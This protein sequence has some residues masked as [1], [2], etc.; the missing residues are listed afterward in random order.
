M[1]EVN[2]PI[3]YAGPGSPTTKIDELFEYISDTVIDDSELPSGFFSVRLA[4]VQE[5]LATNS[6]TV[7][8]DFARALLSARSLAEDM[9]EKDHD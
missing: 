2:E 4:C 3:F 9:V 1:R 8:V 7:C 6:F 5:M